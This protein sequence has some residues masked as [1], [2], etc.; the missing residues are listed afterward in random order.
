MLTKEVSSQ[1]VMEDSLSDSKC[2]ASRRTAYAKS[3]TGYGRVEDWK[4]FLCEW[5]LV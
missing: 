4:A 1:A 5:N 3:V 2:I